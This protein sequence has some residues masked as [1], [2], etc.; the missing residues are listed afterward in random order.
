MVKEGIE[1]ILGFL[2][3]DGRRLAGHPV[4]EGKM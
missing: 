4:T 1:G 3:N 2:V